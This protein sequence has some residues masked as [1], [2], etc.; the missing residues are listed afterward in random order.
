MA[1]QDIIISNDNPF[2]E[3]RRLKRGGRIKE[4]R[5]RGLL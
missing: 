1:I 5:I 3:D 4:N 2:F